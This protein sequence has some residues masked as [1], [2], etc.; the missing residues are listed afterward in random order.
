LSQDLVV[1]IHGYFGHPL[2]MSP[3]ARRF[4]QA[5]FGTYNWGYPSVWKDIAAHAHSFAGLLDELAAREEVQRLFVVA[6]SM[7]CIVTRQA[8]LEKRPSK[9]SRVLLLCPP[10]RG[11]HAAT[12]FAPWFG[13]FSRTLTEMCDHPGSWVNR[14]PQTL[15]EHVPVGIIVANG[16]WVVARECTHL[17]GVDHVH[18]IG[19]MHAGIL[20]KPDTARAAIHFLREGRFPADA[21]AVARHQVSSS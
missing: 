11:S 10:N 7:G 15:S 17:T 9:L 21:A 2:V 14:L 8:L 12:R 16:D 19:G 3:L 6:H 18:V 1:L 5:G 13:W 20:A 4:Q